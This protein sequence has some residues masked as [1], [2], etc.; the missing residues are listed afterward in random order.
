MVSSSILAESALQ[1]NTNYCKILSSKRI[2]TCEF[3]FVVTQVQIGIGK[4]LDD[5]S[6]EACEFVEGFRFAGV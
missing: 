1:K 6:E 5:L 3:H 2:P 4:Q